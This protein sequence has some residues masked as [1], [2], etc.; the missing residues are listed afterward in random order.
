MTQ[1][2]GR[3][4]SDL[5]EKIDVIDTKATH[6]NTLEIDLTTYHEQRAGSLVLDPK[7]VRFLCAR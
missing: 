7:Y 5:D 2:Q 6:E 3:P 4:K 1:L